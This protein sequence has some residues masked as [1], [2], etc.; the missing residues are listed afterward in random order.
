[1]THKFHSHANEDVMKASMVVLILMFRFASALAQ[2]PSGGVQDGGHGSGGDEKAEYTISANPGWNLVS[3]PIAVGDYRPTVVFPAAL[4]GAY[5]YQAGYVL[6][7]TLDSGPGYWLKFGSSQ[8]ISLSGSLITSD[9]IPVAA[10]WNIVGSISSP[11]ASS[12]VTP[13][14]TS[15]QSGYFTFDNGYQSA[16][17]IE[18]G[19]GYWVKTSTS[20]SLV[21]SSGSV[22]ASKRESAEEYLSTLN[23]IS[24]LDAAGSRQ[25]LYFAADANDGEFELPPVPP[26]GAFDARF[27][28]QKMV[29]GQTA[30]ILLASAVYP[31]DVHW[32][33]AVPG[34]YALV[35]NGKEIPLGSGGSSHVSSSSAHLSLRVGAATA[36]PTEFAL[37]QNYP[38]P[39][40][41]AT[42]IAYA[43]PVGTHEVVSLSV[44][45]VL[46]REV[47]RLVNEV[48]EPGNYEV[49]WDA[50]NVASGVYYSRLHAGTFQATR[51][52]LLLK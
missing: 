15:L 47:A 3:V 39:F 14:G 18:P 36:L 43:I 44:F 19:K 48:K 24:I 27:A 28:S 21:M 34:D 8:A 2:F 11:I 33:I 12:S 4:T 13:V 17:T 6:E 35:I 31:L 32:D 51:K 1:M 42:R 10:G 30:E 9:T 49:Q 23:S 16:S 37:A 46:G 52:M 20:G 5:A 38:N 45:D 26:A 50:G 29:T 25:T 22:P 41:P 40:N 7:D